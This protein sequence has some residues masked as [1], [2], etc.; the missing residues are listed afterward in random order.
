MCSKSL[1]KAKKNI[2]FPKSQNGFLTLVFFCFIVFQVKI[3]MRIFRSK[4]AQLNEKL[5]SLE[6]KIEYLEA[7][8][9]GEDRM[10]VP[11]A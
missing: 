5:T 9:S 1:F 11:E 8:V 2:P 4:L 7:R 3:N 10:Q 6:R